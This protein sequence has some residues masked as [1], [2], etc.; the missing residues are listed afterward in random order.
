MSVEIRIKTRTPK[1]ELSKLAKEVLEVLLGKAPDKHGIRESFF[2]AV[3]NSVYSSIHKA[4]LAKKE[5]GADELGNKWKD[6]APATKAYKKL[7]GRKGLSLPGPLS[8]PTLNAT[9]DKAWRRH[10]VRRFIRLVTIMPEEKAKRIA[11]ASAWNH[12]KESHGATTLLD[13]MKSKKFPLNFDTGD[14]ERSLEPADYSPPGPY[15]PQDPNQ[16]VKLE[17]GK[18]VLGSRAPNASNA[19]KLRPLWPRPFPKEWLTKAIR[20]G[21]EAIILRIKEI[22]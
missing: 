6:H 17:S 4:F 15:L 1:K 13:I 8:R 19:D 12:V 5:H 14:T 11:A 20:E 22:L 10:F 18:L 16:I 7:E 2:G 3:T 9:Q 21:K